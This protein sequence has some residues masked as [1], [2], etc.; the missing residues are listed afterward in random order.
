MQVRPRLTTHTL[1]NDYKQ[2]VKSLKKNNLFACQLEDGVLV[3][4]KKNGNNLDCI[5]INPRNYKTNGFTSWT[6][7]FDGLENMYK[8]VFCNKENNFFSVEI[9]E[10][11]MRDVCFSLAD[12]LYCLKIGEDYG[13]YKMRKLN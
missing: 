7:D 13:G 5:M 11:S 2:I 4:V 3:T 1:E 10:F 6:F 8:E 9:G 12:S